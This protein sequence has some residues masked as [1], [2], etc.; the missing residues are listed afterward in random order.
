LYLDVGSR[1]QYFCHYGARAFS[2]RLTRAGIA[3]LFE[4]FDDDHS[5][6]DYRMDRSLPFLY[7]AVS[8]P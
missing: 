7:Q 4:E 1:D 3:H 5:S 6:V 8:A 2:R